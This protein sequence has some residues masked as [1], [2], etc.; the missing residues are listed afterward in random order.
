MVQIKTAIQC[1]FS[2]TIASK[3]YEPYH[4][5]DAQHDPIVCFEYVSGTL[6]PNFHLLITEISCAVFLDCETPAQC[7]AQEWNA[8]YMPCLLPIERTSFDTSPNLPS[9]Q[10]YHSNLSWQI[11]CCKVSKSVCSSPFQQVVELLGVHRSTHWI[12][13][14]LVHAYC[15]TS[16][17]GRKDLLWNGPDI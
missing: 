16:K 15:A 6:W 3:Q 2:P 7:F 14:T 11:R 4:C 8:Q 1:L 5:Q 13:A 12:D 17:A 10:C 9:P